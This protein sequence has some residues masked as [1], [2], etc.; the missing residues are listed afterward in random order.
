MRSNPDTYSIE[1][2][3][4]RIWAIIRRVWRFTAK[5]FERLRSLQRSRLVIINGAMRFMSTAPEIISTKSMGSST[6]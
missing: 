6:I 3:K 5:Y 1:T 2:N 4:A